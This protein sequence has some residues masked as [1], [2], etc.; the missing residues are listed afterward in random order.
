MSRVTVKT[1]LGSFG[2]EMFGDRAPATCAHFRSV[3]RSGAFD[4]ASVF[5]IVGPPNHQ[6]G[7]PNPIEVIQLGP[8]GCVESEH[9]EVP[10][11]ST[12]ATG[13]KHLRGTVSAG[14]VDLGHLFG[15]FFVCMRDEPALD[16]GAGR[17]PD[18]QGFAAFGQVISGFGVLEKIMQRAEAS[19]FLTREIPILSVTLENRH[20][21]GEDD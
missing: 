18:Q 10:H 19:D 14:R 4:D 20:D 1:T 12:K 11:E 6:P 17:H 9:V 15:S 16:H 21:R 13:L 3:I 2:F 8:R 7:E 5:R